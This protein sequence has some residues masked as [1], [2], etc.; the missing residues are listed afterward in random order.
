MFW[1]GVYIEPVG[2]PSTNMCYDE[3]WIRVRV[4]DHRSIGVVYDI[5]LLVVKIENFF[6]VALAGC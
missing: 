4:L 3:E 6:S 1:K 2:I 5:F